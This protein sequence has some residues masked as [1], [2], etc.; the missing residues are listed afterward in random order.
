MST[1]LE[2]IRGKHNEA[3]ITLEEIRNREATLQAALNDA[4][5]SHAAEVELL[6]S[7]HQKAIDDKGAEVDELITKLKDEHGSALATLRDE[8]VVSSS[9]LDKAHRDHEE[10]F[11]KLS[12]SHEELR[13]RVQEA[14]DVLARTRDDHERSI[15]RITAE[16]EE[17]LK[18]KDAA[19]N[20][21]LQSTE[22]EYYNALTKLRCDHAE[23]LKKH[24]SE[25]NATLERLRE[26]HAGELRMIEIAK[27]GLLSESQSSQ[28][29]AIRELQDEHAAAITRKEA[30]FVEDMGRLKAEHVRSLTTTVEDYTLQMDRLRLEHETLLARFKEERRMEVDRLTLAL[31]DAHE[32]ND[33][34]SVRHQ[35]ELEAAIRAIQDRHVAVLRELELQHQEDAKKMKD[36]HERALKDA[37]LQA[38]ADRAALVQSFAEDTLSVKAKHEQEIADVN[39]AL[40]DVREDMKRM[41]EGHETSLTD[42]L[43]KADADRTALIQSHTEDTL[44]ARGRH[45]QEIASINVTLAD[46]QEIHR[47]SDAARQQSERLLT[48]EKERAAT[49]L[50]ELITRHSEELE[51]LRKERDLLVQQLDSQR[52]TQEDTDRRLIEEKDRL[53]QSINE[54]AQRHAEELDTLRKERDLVLQE[55][56]SHKIAADSYSLVRERSREAHE[57][58]LAQK[59]TVIKDM[60]QQLTNTKEERDELEAEVAKLRGELVKTKGEQSKLIQ[61]AS[62]RQSLVDEL[63]R[64][65]SVLAETQESLQRVKD[66]KDT[67]QAEKT[68]ADALVRDLQAQIAR[69]A[70]PPNGRPVAERNVSYTRS[71]AL[72]PMK[73]PPP[74]PPPSVPPPPAPRAPGMVNGDASGSTSSHGSSTINTSVSSRD[75]QP[76]S[77]ATSLS[78]LPVSPTSPLPVDSKVVARLEHQAKQIE[79]QEAM[80]KTLNKQLTHCETDLQTHMD[81]VTTL[82]ASLGDSEKNRKY[83][84]SLSQLAEN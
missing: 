2:V 60:E 29:S 46:V 26:E 83:R 45:E 70:S 33:A 19:A 54:L 40:A 67:I 80:I 75:S 48:E 1:E 22:E 76:E 15:A 58:D 57:H 74:T 6:R 62:K 71:T 20:V 23:A 27:E 8:L 59:T 78:H 72:S 13:R 16:H 35:T 24:T 44:R 64:H 25:L 42:A 12:E 47:G 3:I 52:T 32:A 68:R 31:K 56:D 61:E 37:L 9:A 82:E 55:L 38:E 69:S 79:E 5:T 18:Q 21:V 30:S 28:I 17:L 41:K 63:E 10:A 73:L 43:A 11:G 65:R 81:L 39:A 51:A 14:N 84:L 36:V 49:L 53:V 66:E 50:H 34:A 4:E 7:Q 77:P